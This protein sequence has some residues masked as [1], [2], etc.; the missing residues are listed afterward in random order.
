MR[1]QA[2]TFIKQVQVDLL[3]LSDADLFQTIDQWRAGKE[4]SG[5]SQDAL[6]VTWSALGYTRAPA[7]TEHF[8]Y[9]PSTKPGVEPEV[10]EHWLAPSPHHLR[11]LLTE[12]DVKQFAQHVIAIAY[13]SLH[14]TYPEWGDGST[15]NAHLANHLRWMRMHRRRNDQSI[16]ITPHV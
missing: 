11:R 13:Q 4:S 7:V 16:S 14:A 6:E 2:Q 10:G 9:P 1:Y 15:F 5:L 3:A 12:M 8:S